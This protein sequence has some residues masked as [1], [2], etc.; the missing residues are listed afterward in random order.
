MRKEAVTWIL[1][2]LLTTSGCALLNRGGSTPMNEAPTKE[3]EQ[4]LRDA[5]VVARDIVEQVTGTR[6]PE[7][8]TRLVLVPGK[9]DGRYYVVVADGIEVL[10]STDPRS[11]T[12][13]VAVG[14]NGELPLDLTQ[15]LI[16]EQVH[17]QGE[18]WTHPPAF[19]GKVWNWKGARETWGR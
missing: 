13:S 14:P 18:I 9:V 7:A 11:G 15:I 1:V 4:K 17:R 5:G 2:S 16:H 19:D 6:P 8:H 10:A 12:I 3:L